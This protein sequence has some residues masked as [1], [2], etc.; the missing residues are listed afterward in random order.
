MVVTLVARR[1]ALSQVSIVTDFHFRFAPRHAAGPINKKRPHQQDQGEPHQDSIGF[2]NAP[3]SA[4]QTDPHQDP[5]RAATVS[6]LYRRRS[7]SWV[8]VDLGYTHD[9]PATVCSEA[10][11][12]LGSTPIDPGPD[13]GGRLQHTHGGR[14]DR[15]GARK[16]LEPQP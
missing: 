7:V 4:P 10:T 5:T 9:P 16:R 11:P 6:E 8:R 13:F 1:V 2:P 15:V 12:V 14:R 3:K